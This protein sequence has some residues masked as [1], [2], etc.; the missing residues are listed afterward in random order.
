[1]KQFAT[2]LSFLLALVL[3]G[4]SLFAQKSVDA[5][6]DLNKNPERYGVAPA[7]VSDLVVT[8]NYAS[9][10]GVEHVYL[11]QLHQG[12]LIHNAQ[13]SV[14]FKGDRVIHRTSTLVPN[15]GSFTTPPAPAFSAQT[16]VGTVANDLASSFTTIS[17]RGRDGMEE[18]FD[19]PGISMDPAR[20]QLVYRTID[21]GLSLQYRVTIDAHRTGGKS[22]LVFVDATTGEIT[23]RQSMTIECSFG[24]RPHQHHFP[25]PQAPAGPTFDPET[26]VDGASY[27]VV[28]FGE[29]SPIHGDFAEEKSPADSLASPFGWH[30]VN[31]Q[32]GAEFTYTR[33]NNT[34]TYP[35]REVGDDNNNSSDTDTLA[36][37][38][39]EL[40]FRYDYSPLNQPDDNI[41]AGLTQLFYTTNKIHDWL[42]HHGF[43]EAAG[44]FQRNNYGNGGAAGDEVNAEAQDGSGTNNAN[45][46]TPRDGNRPRMQM[47]LWTGSNSSMQISHPQNLAGGYL[48]GTADFGRSIQ[49]NDPVTAPLVQALD[50]SASPQLGCE[51]IVNADEIAGKIAFVTRGECLFELKSRN[52]QDA[53]AVGLVICNNENAIINMTGPGDLGVTIPVVSMPAGTC[54]ELRVR[55]AA[56]DSI[57]VTFSFI[58][59]PPTPSEFD[60]G[61]VAHEYGHGVSNRLVGGPDNTFCLFNDEQMGEG[62]S[63]FLALASTPKTNLDNP[64]GTEPRGI[65]N[66]ALGN[67][68]GARGIRRQVYSTD[69]SVNTQTYNHIIWSGTAPHPVGEVWNTALWDLYWAF[70]D[71]YGFDDDLIQGDGG[72]NRAFELVLE[73]M[74]FTSCNPGLVDGRDG[75]LAAD[76]AL[77]NG[78]HQCMIYDVFAR[79]G[80]GFDATQGSNDD[81]T[82]NNEGFERSPYCT[83]QIT[84]KKNFKDKTIDAGENVIV[85]LDLFSYRPGT[86]KGIELRETIPAGYTVDV[87]SV[88][89]DEVTSATMDGDQLVL[90]INDMD[91]EDEA[92]ISYTLTTPSLGSQQSFFDGAE[93]SDDNWEYIDLIGANF[94]ELTD[95][96]P[97]EGDA[98]YYVVNVGTE[99]DQTLTTFEPIEMTGTNP[100]LRFFTQYNTEAG[101]DGGFVEVSTD[102]STWIRLA[103]DDLVRGGYRGTAAPEATATLLGAGSFWGRSAGYDEIMVD[104]S[105][106]AGQEVYLRWRMI[107]DA[108]TSGRGW[109][110][111]NIEILDVVNADPISRL[112]SQEGDDVTVTAGDLGVLLMG[113][114]PNSTVD[115]ELGQTNVRVFPNPASEVANVDIT[116]ERAG[117][118]TVRLLGVDGRVLTHQTL[119]LRPG[120]NR[121]TLATDQLPAGIYLVQVSGAELVSTVKL[122]VR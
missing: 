71:L 14:H 23:E 43:D 109:W 53:G 110:V 60:N 77:F 78:D 57:S 108:N 22:W 102:N 73:G 7:D 34:Y 8:D 54:D 103:D 15:L 2:C 106:Y 49:G 85:E 95:T 37:G 36:D 63:D 81:R 51:T 28:P 121:T 101:W 118:A 120:T 93:D 66:F 112:T 89:S 41:A 10:N 30:D 87:A 20:A 74:K 5:V 92:F 96:T 99:Q 107:S 21:A 35:D 65:G 26:V 24:E 3:T 100:H 94:W 47:M 45:F 70:V 83:P 105:Q 86:T 113:G 12:V 16:A 80:V 4:G 44:N 104:L 31:G 48:T 39:A 58:D 97:Y 115:A 90:T 114:E 50:G 72:N 111:D 18:L 69:M 56:G 64:D 98:V 59:I 19:V 33:G 40:D 13:A 84:V 67:T 76:E 25:L 61:I 119:E 116:S 46:S 75:I 52:V 38:G 68:I 11:A 55:L 82:D 9:R 29:E 62:W 91:F 6:N 79:R 88:D 122:T 32:E 42:W 17:S 1:M 27:L 117:Q